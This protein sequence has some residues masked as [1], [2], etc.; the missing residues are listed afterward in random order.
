MID[1]ISPRLLF[2]SSLAASFL[3]IV[4]MIV[5]FN[6]GNQL[7]SRHAPLV[8]AAMELKLEAVGRSAD[9][10]AI[11]ILATVKGTNSSK[12]SLKNTRSSLITSTA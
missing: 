12:K 7:A 10:N 9:E 6:L 11:A 5:L 3:F 2:I 8:D 4:V 1:K